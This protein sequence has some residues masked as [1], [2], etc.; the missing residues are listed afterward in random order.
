MNRTLD[1]ERP[2]DMPLTTHPLRNRRFGQLATVLPTL[3]LA[4]CAS[5]V[6]SPADMPLQH[7]DQLLR[8]AKTFGE[9]R[10]AAEYLEQ[11][12]LARAHVLPLVA[13]Y[14]VA[15]AIHAEDSVLEGQLD[16]YLKA[17]GVDTRPIKAVHHRDVGAEQSAQLET[18]AASCRRLLAE[19]KADACPS[20]KAPTEMVCRQVPSKEAAWG[21]GMQNTFRMQDALS[22]DIQAR[23]QGNSN[24]AYAAIE[25]L[26]QRQQEKDRTK[27]ECTV[28][29]GATYNDT[30]GAQSLQKCAGAVAALGVKSAGHYE[31]A[32]RLA[33]A[34]ALPD[35]SR[36]A[37][38]ARS[39]EIERE[40]RQWSSVE[41]RVAAAPC[42]KDTRA[43]VAP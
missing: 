20:K 34:V 27:E 6:Q 9:Y 40:S 15:V 17:G 3:L 37:M 39:S 38:F 29:G 7:G 11:G 8:D 32:G 10:E 22:A 21:Q 16:D 19:W 13:H 41:Q 25:T 5:H 18:Q 31:A 28:E 1:S 2:T 14:G 33:A 4:N 36:E 26:T 23:M 43:V 12:G 24:T 42:A 30:T 35:V